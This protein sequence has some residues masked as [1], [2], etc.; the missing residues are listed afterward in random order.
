[1]VVDDEDVAVADRGADLKMVVFE[2]G[3]KW[4]YW[5]MG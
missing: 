4:E 1:V 3:S 2:V 5:T